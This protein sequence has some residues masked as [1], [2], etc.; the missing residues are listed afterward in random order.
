M[1][2][3][4]GALVIAVALALPATALA[5]GKE[6]RCYGLFLAD[7]PDEA[8]IR[9]RAAAYGAAPCAV[10]L[11]LDW[12]AAALPQPALR[13]IRRAGAVPF[14]ALE[15]WHAS[16]KQGVSLSAI[17]SG[18]EDAVLK[19][20]GGQLRAL[21]GEALVRFGHEMNGNWYPWSGAA[22]GKRPDAFIAAWRRVHDVVAAAAAPTRIAWVWTVNA[23]DVPAEPW[24]Q[25]QAFYPGDAF[26]DAI[27]ID[28]YNWGGTRPGNPWKSFDE[29]FG[30]Q[31]QRLR[32]TFPG[33][34]VVIAE[35]GSAP[36]PQR[37]AWMEDFFAQLAAAHADL[38]LFL[39][40]DVAKEADWR[41]GSDAASVAAFRRGVAAWSGGRGALQRAL[42]GGE[43]KR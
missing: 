32:Q 38:A 14:I 42:F 27:G 29:V 39:W 15:P 28:G 34:P 16:S 10:S 33:K 2:R 24:N 40:F 31:L 12:D 23:E 11:F 19:A 3:R 17:A 6:R 18:R 35:V 20:F 7:A 37:G 22:N 36:G 1:R 5:G 41:I 30:A 26:A 21:G 4:L 25:A 43:R 13:E 9:E 8:G